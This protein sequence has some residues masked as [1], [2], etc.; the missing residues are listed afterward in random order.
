MFT[1]FPAETEQFFMD[2][3]FHNEPAFF[4][5]EHERYL[6]V[7]QRPFYD[8]IE[9]IMPTLLEIDPQME[10]R[11]N[12]ILARIHRDTRFTKDKSPY[13]D[14]LWIFFHRTA[15]DK[16]GSAG[17]WF[18]YGA[19]RIA[20]GMGSWGENRPVMDRFRRELVADPERYIRLIRNC[21]FPS[22]NLVMDSDFFKRMDVP[23]SLPEALKPWYLSKSISIIQKYPDIGACASRRILEWVRE[24]FRAMSPIYLMLRGMQDE[25]NAK[26]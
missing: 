20:W 8:F 5:R 7:V 13:R 26:E 12:K 23:A 3:R 11:P 25:L 16:H 6:S 2:L 1:G 10:P 21:H 14:H 9:D 17:F 4:H 22:R 18:E 19:G 24:D 15:E